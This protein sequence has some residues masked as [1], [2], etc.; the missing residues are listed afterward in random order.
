MEWLVLSVR[1]ERL[2]ERLHRSHT[3]AVL[4]ILC[5]PQLCE[6][7]SI[8]LSLAEKGAGIRSP[9][10]IVILQAG[11]TVGMNGWTPQYPG[12]EIE[13]PCKS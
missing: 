10:I 3:S 8:P 1:G 11:N 7:P 13:R 12:S 2:A 4:R 5:S 9:Q 6:S